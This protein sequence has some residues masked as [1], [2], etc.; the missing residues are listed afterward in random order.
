MPLTEAEARRLVN[1]RA[2]GRCERCGAPG[3]LTY[4]HRIKRSQGGTWAP[5]NALRLCGS[6][7]TGCHGWSE[8]NPLAAQDAGIALPSHADPRNVPALIHP[9]PLWRA[10]WALDDAGNYQLVEADLVDDARRAAYALA[11]QRRSE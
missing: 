1:A 9:A 2:G 5:S 11:R 8:A 4:A 6:G 10:W 7:T 3:P